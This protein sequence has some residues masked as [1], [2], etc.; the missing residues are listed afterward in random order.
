MISQCRKAPAAAK[1]RGK[2]LG[3]PRLAD[4]CAAINASRMAGVEAHADAFLAS[5]SRGPGCRGEVA[6]ADRRSP[7]WTEHRHSTRWEMGGAAGGEY[8]MSQLGDLAAPTVRRRAGFQGDIASW[9]RSQKPRTLSRASFR[10]RTSRSPPS[11]AS[12]SNHFSARSTPILTTWRLSSRAMIFA[13]PSGNDRTNTSA[14]FGA[15]GEKT[16]G[17]IS[18]FG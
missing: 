13:T 7:E 16:T 2:T 3:N 1:A 5:H 11:T 15:V 8:P 4:A 17:V 12:I 10:F 14:I 18:S 6:W 9:K